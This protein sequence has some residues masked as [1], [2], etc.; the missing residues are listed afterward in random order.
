MI[1][2]Q[3]AAAC[4]DQMNALG[5]LLHL[6]ESEAFSRGFEKRRIVE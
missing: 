4:W 6:K 5:G 2:Y 1:S 3:V